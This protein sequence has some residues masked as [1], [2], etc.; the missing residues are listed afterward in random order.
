MLGNLFKKVT[1][2]DIVESLKSTT[3]KESKLNSMIEHININTK[4]QDLQNFLHTIIP[5]NRIESV[6]WLIKKGI[7]VNTTDNIGQTPI[8]L[9][10]KYGYTD[11]VDAL[12]KADANVEFE[13]HNGYTAIEFAILNNHYKSYKKI[14][15]Y[16]KNISRRNKNNLTLL[17]LAIK[18]ENIKIIEDLLNDKNF[19]IS[20]EL[21]FY[22]Y[23]FTNPSVLNLVL[24]KFDNLQIKDDFGRNILFYVVENGFESEDIFLRLLSD[25]LDIDCID[26]DGNN[27]LIHL[28]K[29]II[30]K[31]NSLKKI[32]V[33]KREPFEK[34]IKS[35]INF[36]PIILEKNIKTDICNNKNETIISL[37]TIFKCKDI[38]NVL[39][40]Y[41][42]DINI[43]NRNHENALSQ[44]IVKGNDYTEINHLLI[45]YGANPNIKD[46]EEKN[47]IEKLIDAILITKNSKK[48]LN[49]IKR[50]LDF[51]CDYYALIES[52]LINTDVN[53]T[54]L[55]SKGEPF[56]FEALK[57]GNID[58]LKLL[59]RHGADINQVDIN[60]KNILYKFMEE[61]QTFQKEVE[62]KE[63][64]HK[65]QTII[66]MG[67][68]V[69]AKDSYGGITLHKAI[70]DCDLITIKLLFHSGA[71]MEALDNRG[72]N[73][74]HNSIWKNDIKVFKLVYAY[75]KTLLN[76]PDKFGVLPINYAAFLGYTELVLEII[77]LN[78]QINNPYRKSKYILNFLK[79]FH[80][81]LKPLVEN[82]RTK[83][84][85]AKIKILIDNMKKEFEVK[86]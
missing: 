24:S 84:Q 80:K 20:N 78:G 46:V 72:R 39:F 6:K 11:S 2:E 29:I 73:I 5:E 45:D 41:D 83:S 57:Y 21:L 50:D 16:I 19:E 51:K 85:R 61:N 17:H 33:D 36:I 77:E 54:L 53:L 30:F 55:N 60:G 14:K 65:L 3:F 76:D 22:K 79:K 59:I 23:S 81:N 34:E 63:Y 42:T 9:A 37:P 8:M 7:N 31:E 27:I 82:T 43:L 86:D 38:L 35:L 68:N 18:A 40:E 12:L 74:M 25:G 52:V 26:K 48:V 1:S 10:A 44:I 47:S 32:D 28:I 13:D 49:S 4:N 75:N 69:N 15:E 67:A 66:M 58:L 62:Q 56:I 70:L 64:H 71:D